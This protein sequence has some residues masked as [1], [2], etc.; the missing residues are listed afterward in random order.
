MLVLEEVADERHRITFPCFLDCFPF[1]PSKTGLD[2]STS[3]T[4]HPVLLQMRDTTT[5]TL[6][7]LFPRQLTLFL[8]L[9]QETDTLSA[10]SQTL[11]APSPDECCILCLPIKKKVLPANS[12]GTTHTKGRFPPVAKVNLMILEL[13]F[14]T[15]TFTPSSS[16]SRIISVD[17]INIRET[18][19]LLPFPWYSSESLFRHLIPC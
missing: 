9:P 7:P 17:C 6:F 3:Q 16:T 12:R 4:L 8:R 2:T 19:N 18:P 11:S 13:L 15:S 5:P 14:P 10:P 1:V